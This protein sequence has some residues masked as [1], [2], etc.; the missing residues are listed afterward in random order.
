MMSLDASTLLKRHF[1]SERATRTRD[2]SAEEV[3]SNQQVAAESLSG[4]E[5]AKF[6]LSVINDANSAEPPTPSEGQHH[7][8]PVCRQKGDPSSSTHISSLAHQVALLSTNR[9]RPSPLFIPPSNRGYRL[10][11]R[12]GWVDAADCPSDATPA[13]QLSEDSSASTSDVLKAGGL[14][15]EGQGR[16]FPIATVL[17]RDRRG[18]GAA[19][20]DG[21]RARITHFSPGDISAV[22]TQREVQL[23]KRPRRL[24]LDRRLRDKQLRTEKQFERRFRQ[25]F[26]FTD[27][28]LELLY[29]RT[30]TH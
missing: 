26:N 9:P 18:L 24:V 22:L 19:D 20:P 10:L 16:R 5:A 11:R 8:C 15:R 30:Y 23:A 14:G 27:E 7:L 6:Y 25:E 28:E 29:G 12:L 21:V 2:N 3:R 1:V 4:T 17:K 13:L